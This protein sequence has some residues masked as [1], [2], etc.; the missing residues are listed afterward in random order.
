V[1][2]LIKCRDESLVFDFSDIRR[3]YPSCFFV[4]RLNLPRRVDRLTWKRVARVRS[5]KYTGSLSLLQ[6]YCTVVVSPVL[7][8]TNSY[9]CT[10]RSRV[11]G[12]LLVLLVSVM[13]WTGYNLR[14]GVVREELLVGWGC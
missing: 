10:K 14:S 11:S 1:P 12:V 5:G 3:R 13:V 9:S 4:I 2:Q 6:K 8:T 7:S